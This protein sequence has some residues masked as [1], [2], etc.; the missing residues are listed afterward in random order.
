MN[1][2]EVTTARLLVTAGRGPRECELAVVRVAELLEREAG[3]AGLLAATEVVGRGA[4]APGARSVALTISGPSARPWAHAQEGPVRWISASPLRPRHQRRNWFVE[5][6]AE[7]ERDRRE[8]FD[9]AAV[10]YEAIRSG[11]PGGQRRNKVATA[12]RAHHIPSGHVV[13]AATERTLSANRKAA[14]ARLAALCEADAARRDTL[15]GAQQWRRHDGVTRGNPV[16]TIR[17]PLQ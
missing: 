13:V 17:A 3:A 11:G 2:R 4:R 1:P 14:R 9:D 6:F 12:V 10:A 16:R 8:P 15:S 5:V 7:E